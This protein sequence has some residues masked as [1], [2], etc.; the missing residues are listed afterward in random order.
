VSRL[1]RGLAGIHLE[2]AQHQLLLADRFEQRVDRARLADGLEHDLQRSA[3][4]QAPARRVL[5]GDAV[6]DELR[7]VRRNL[8]AL[9][10]VDQVVLDAPAGDRAGDLPIVA[11][12]DH[13]ADRAR[14]RAP[15]LDDRAERYAVSRLAP[16]FGAAEDF[17]VYAVHGVF[18][19]FTY[20]IIVARVS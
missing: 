8:A 7:L 2:P 4:R 9:H 5:I 1:E 12:R 17:D 11:D 18:L 3:A 16:R 6:S 19:S 10:L 20:R 15:G 13:R 14:R